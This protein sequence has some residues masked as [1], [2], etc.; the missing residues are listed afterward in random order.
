MKLSWYELPTGR[1]VLEAESTDDGEPRLDPS[2]FIFD[3]RLDSRLYD[4]IWVAAAL[5]FGERIHGSWKGDFPISNG[6]AK[7]IR[8]FIGDPFEFH[9]DDTVAD[10][11]LHSFGMTMGIV[12]S[13]SIENRAVES[14][15]AEATAPTVV[16][17][18]RDLGLWS[19]RLFNIRRLTVASNSFVHGKMLSSSGCYGPYLALGVL[20]A[21]DLGVDQIAVPEN[22]RLFDSYSTLCSSVGID[23]L[24]VPVTAVNPVD[25][26]LKVVRA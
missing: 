25:G 13:G 2:R 12:T 18:I 5:I 3:A 4:R 8:S 22:E 19:G 21:N 17:D 1:T 6:V 23:L 24:P 10:S 16:L 14:F 26:D 15:C 11:N 20:L 9:V 7:A